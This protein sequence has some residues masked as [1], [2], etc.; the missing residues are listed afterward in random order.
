[1]KRSLTLPI[2]LTAVLAQTV[3]AQQNYKRAH[4]NMLDD[5]KALLAE[6]QYLEASKIYKK[7]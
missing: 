6:G 7:L 2:L 4:N 1:M 3:N 5:A